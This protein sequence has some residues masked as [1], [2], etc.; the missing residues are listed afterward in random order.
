MKTKAIALVVV[1]LVS[2]VS[3]TITAETKAKANAQ[4]KPG[5]KTSPAAKAQ[6]AYASAVKAAQTAN[7]ALAPLRTAMQKAD[8]AY[9]K[10]KKIADAKRQQATNAKNLSGQPGVKALKQAQDNVPIATKA[11]EAATKAKPPLD[12][13]LVKARADALPLQKAYDVAEKE[14]RAAEAVAKRAFDAAN[15]L[16]ADAQF[17]TAQALAKRR[18]ANNAKNTLARAQQSEKALLAQANTLPKKLV[19]AEK[20][21]IATEKIVAPINKRV[22]AAQAAYQTAE[23]AAKTAQSNARIVTQTQKQQAVTNATA[24]R[25]AASAAKTSLTKTQRYT[26]NL[27]TKATAINKTLTGSASW[28][29][30]AEAAVTAA[31]KQ[32]ATAFKTARTV[33]QIA[34]NASLKAKAVAA[35]AGKSAAE[36]KQAQ[37]EAAARRKEASAAWAGLTQTKKAEKTATDRVAMIAKNLTAAKAQKKPTDAALI[38][39]RKKVAALS[40]A[41]Q[42]AERAALAAEAYAKRMTKLA[43]RPKAQTQ[44]AAADAAAKRKTAD[45]AKAVLNRALKAQQKPLALAG[46][47]A[48]TFGRLQ[49]RKKMLDAAL[50]NAKM[51]ITAAT[52][53]AVATEKTALAFEKTAAQKQQLANQ[54]AAKRKVIADASGAL[55]R[56]KDAQR[57]AQLQLT[58]ASKPLAALTAKKKSANTAWLSARKKLTTAAAAFKAADKAAATAAAKAKQ[59]SADAGKSGDE[60]KR[61]SYDAT[62]KRKAAAAQKAGLTQA[63]KNEKTAAAALAAINKQLIAAQAKKKQADTALA[64]AKPKIAAAGIAVQKARQAAG[65]LTQL[66]DER[67][68][69][70]MEAA[71]KRKIAKAAQT[72][73]TPKQKILEQATV[74][75][76]SAA[77]ALVRAKARKK[78]AETGLVN[79]KARIASSKKTHINDAKAASAAEAVAAPLKVTAGKTR[80]AYV[81]ARKVSD[82]KRDLAEQAKGVL[83]RLLAAG[84]VAG[85]M[86]S[87]EAP[88]PTNRIDEIVFAKLK[89]LGVKPVLCSDSVFVRR[90]FLDL[91]GKLPT[92]RE[93]RAFIKST[94]TKK[95]TALIDNLLD[96]TEHVD[97]LAMKWSDILRVKAEFPV[98]VWPNAAQ[99]YHRWVWKSIAQNVPYDKFARQLL[100]S[101]GS[102][103]RVGAVNFYRAIQNKTPEGI[104]SSVGLALMGAR[105]HSWP[106][107][108]RADMAVFFSQV[109]YKPTSEWKEEVIFWD[110]LHSTK[111]PGS[112]APGIKAV[113]KSVTETNKIPQALAKPMSPNGPLPAVFP[114]GTKTTI[115]PNRDPRVVFADW[116]IRP[117]NPWF[118]KAIVN[119]TWAWAMGRG[120]IHE[121]DDIRKG[122]PP[123][124]PELLAYLEKELV[125]NRYDMKHLKRLIFT[126]TVYQLSSIARSKNPQAKA[127]F[128][129]YRMRR[130]EAEVLID[131]LNDITGSSDLYTSAVPEPF[132]YIPRGMGAVT[133]ADG[134]V[135]SSFLSLFGRSA[136]ATGMENERVSELASPQWL[137]MLNSATLQNKLQRSTKLSKMIAS[138]GQADKIAENLYLTILSRFPTDADVKTAQ[139]YAKIKTSKGRD[140]WIDLAWALINSPEFL[141]RH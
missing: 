131:A 140:I 99:A 132:T 128:A 1:L 134:S 4:A 89:T 102:N 138:S 118:A 137:H 112:I 94:S 32:T 96:R 105:L 85:I 90:A 42:T 97:Y 83:Y 59:I 37:D 124:N 127:N 7:A 88:K 141:L 25:K 63:Q 13:A 116:L 33:E 2:S 122:N 35:D 10:A 133:L 53:R 52:P 40:T 98:K 95:R 26:K 9:A 135:T 22:D 136:R 68:R 8:V 117:E 50:A 81:A 41:S 38:S 72:A 65:V 87:T 114:D 110:P 84:R 121:T 21:K 18:I 5:A 76:T 47:A 111:V 103:F 82:D 100:T 106:E 62:A 31:K 58:A 77:Q 73:L 92:A 56:A 125:S 66:D 49:A 69:T 57:Q 109:G 12:Q 14:A 36:K 15:K 30:A 6:A 123:S 45:A 44:Q 126:S 48:Q 55:K 86:E 101:S 3:L 24:K 108:R 23:Q 43:A 60:K 130:V 54:A 113:A 91:T 107:E 19:D 71:A 75:A 120:I 80:A 29:K 115:K 104:A 78:S 61:A 17:A 74:R 34:K 39:A 16:N 129:S 67:W 119:R 70:A 46:A 51:Q 93:A 27:Q 79:L 64:S 28:K 20:K 139:K 11:L